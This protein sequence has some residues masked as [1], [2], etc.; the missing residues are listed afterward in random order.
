[1]ETNTEATSTKPAA[2]RKAV[3][4]EK[5]ALKSLC[6]QLRIEPKVARRRLR[7]A[8]FSWHGSRERWMMTPKQV[9]A[10]REILKPAKPAAKAA[11]PAADKPN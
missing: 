3:K 11:K 2:A 5:T 9:E 4:V 7:K 6:S 1:M 10:A 8:K